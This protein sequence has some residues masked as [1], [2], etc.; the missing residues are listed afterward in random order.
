MGSAQSTP[1]SQPQSEHSQMSANPFTT[2]SAASPPRD[3]QQDI[4]WPLP[5]PADASLLFLKEAA[6]QSS[7]R[8]A[9]NRMP[10]AG[11]S[12]HAPLSERI[13][14]PRLSLADRIGKS[15]AVY[16]DREEGEISDGEDGEDVKPND[17]M[18]LAKRLGR[19]P[20]SSSFPTSAEIQLPASAAPSGSR[21]VGSLADRL[22]LYPSQQAIGRRQSPQAFSR[23]F[24]IISTAETETSRPA[25]PEFPP[26]P[27]LPAAAEPATPPLPPS[28]DWLPSTPPRPAT[29][30]PNEGMEVQTPPLPSL[31]HLPESR[32]PS[33]NDPPPIEEGRPRTPPTPERDD[34][35]D[36]YEAIDGKFPGAMK[37]SLAKTLPPTT[38]APP[39]PPAPPA[40]DVESA[41]LSQ[42]SQAM[43][44]AVERSGA[45][46]AS[47]EKVAQV[48]L[49][50]TEISDEEVNSSAEQAPSTAAASDAIPEDN[51]DYMELIRGLILEGVSPEQLIE[52]GASPQSVMAVCQEI[53]QRTKQPDGSVEQGTTQESVYLT[54]EAE[55][56]LTEGSESR[57]IYVPSSSA[58]SSPALTHLVHP[59]ASPLKASQLK[60]VLSSGL[61]LS[62]PARPAKPI[63]RLVAQE[64]FR[65][66]QPSPR[67]AELLPPT[68]SVPDIPPTSSSTLDTP[69]THASTSSSTFDAPR[70]HA[71]H[72]L[73][74]R[75]SSLPP[76]PSPP[77]VPVSPP[78]KQKSKKQPKGRTSKKQRDAEKKRVAKARGE[79]MVT[80][81]ATNAAVS[82]MTPQERALYEQKQALHE[83]SRERALHEHNLRFHNAMMA[84]QLPPR[85]ETYD[86]HAVAQ[87]GQTHPFP[88]VNP[89]MP[90]HGLHS[91]SDMLGPHV[92]PLEPPGAPPPP[93]D[94]PPPDP[95][96]AALHAR[97]RMALESMRRKKPASVQPEVGVDPVR[98]A[99]DN[100]VQPHDSTAHLHR[101]ASNQ[102]KQ[103]Q[104]HE[105]QAHEQ[106]SAMER[107]FFNAYISGQGSAGHH[108]DQSGNGHET[109]NGSESMDM[110][111]E[112]PEEG[113]IPA[114][115]PVLPIAAMSEVSAP[116]LSEQL[117]GIAGATRRGI[118]RPHAE[119]LLDTRPHSAPPVRRPPAPRRLFGVPLNPT[120]LLLH[121]DD[122]S[123]SDNDDEMEDMKKREEEDKRR[124][125]DEKQ[126]RLNEN[127]L[128][129][130]AEIAM[131]KRRKLEGGTASGVTSPIT[132]NVTPTLGAGVVQ[133][134]ERAAEG[135]QTNVTKLASTDV[136]T[137]SIPNDARARSST[138]ADIRRLTTELAQVEA[139]KEEQAEEFRSI[140]A[141]QSVEEPPIADDDDRMNEEVVI[142]QAKDVTQPAKSSGKTPSFQKPNAYHPI[143]AHYPQ[144]PN[145]V[146]PEISSQNP[147]PN[148][149]AQINQALLDSII[150]TN[151]SQ[152]G[153]SVTLCRAEVGGGKCADRS[154]QSAHLTKGSLIS[155]DEVV[156]YVYEA[157]LIPYG[158]ASGRAR[159][160]VAGV[161][162]AARRHVVGSQAIPTTTI[163]TDDDTLKQL[164]E[165]VGQLL[166]S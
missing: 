69:A 163:R 130:K 164:F 29:P 44:Q 150:L 102:T 6:R 103:S 117:P 112:E 45:S 106:A 90:P 146:A 24:P 128:R 91:N 61:N 133:N 1:G 14:K 54:A 166:Q 92:R 12:S 83:F 119:D 50:T 118:K 17:G 93:P 46:K 148:P 86:S 162:A 158:K 16:G 2:P 137:P 74:P 156:E 110:E 55:S 37:A 53:V 161:V 42:G 72:N 94:H 8:R 9:E 160:E 135:S 75:P 23:S 138:P 60:E 20:A 48:E 47:I 113:E 43:A 30:I 7:R 157:Y 15:K 34:L 145:A 25:S 63:A 97:K 76:A 22:E 10:P 153:N 81:S 143:L 39:T 140:N 149:F 132:G 109:G 131:K 124:E 141:H 95:D 85:P 123:D 147:S 4:Q 126:K 155:D 84:G 70:I 127:I 122:D 62:L 96:A 51:T 87:Y 41:D 59:Q 73:P 49:R 11:S 19:L 79:A 40:S 5:P 71:P 116:I 107:E 58:A 125:A 154:C 101:L 27:P 104:G 31:V 56:S 26:T 57:P 111:L 66:N 13:S 108:P 134:T 105:A 120:R 65:P 159:Q 21:S 52:R 152:T 144:L 32:P 68:L 151:R 115:S 98:P 82:T 64:S 35:V 18:A 100:L 38:S 67:L 89:D 99:I 142:G 129:L 114:P 3:V 121:V 139:Q 136:A 78:S 77:T 88:S 36:K 33:P 165:K 80:R 28:S